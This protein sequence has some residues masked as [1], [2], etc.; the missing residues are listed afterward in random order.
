MLVDRKKSLKLAFK[1][2]LPR[3]DNLQKL[4]LQLFILNKCFLKAHVTAKDKIRSYKS[5]ALPRVRQALD[6]F[7]Q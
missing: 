4:C 7:Q 5:R 1:I 6:F 2:K 3:F